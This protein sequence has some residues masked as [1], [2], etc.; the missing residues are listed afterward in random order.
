MEHVFE[1][2]LTVDADINTDQRQSS[3]YVYMC[4]MSVR[5]W[6]SIF[7]RRS[8]KAS[9]TI[10]VSGVHTSVTNLTF[11]GSSN[12]SSLPEAK[13][14]SILFSVLLEKRI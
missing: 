6:F 1:F 12:L 4:S 7:L 5:Y 11:C 13:K 14:K 8:L 2:M 10:P 9:V 3:I